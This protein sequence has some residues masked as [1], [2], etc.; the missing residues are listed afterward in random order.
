ML[1]LSR[2]LILE[3][4]VPTQLLSHPVEL[5]GLYWARHQLQTIKQGGHFVIELFHFRG[6][7][8]YS[9]WN[10]LYDQFSQLIRQRMVRKTGPLGRA[11][12]QDATHVVVLAKAPHQ[13]GCC[14]DWRS[15]HLLSIVQTEIEKYWQDNNLKDR[16]ISVYL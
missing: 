8:R 15:L 11:Q 2:R 14:A 4:K 12:L 7:S 13:S 6:S 10:N 9:E 5:D 1:R 16:R 3:S